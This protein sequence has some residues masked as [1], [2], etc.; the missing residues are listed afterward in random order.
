MPA[1]VVVRDVEVAGGWGLGGAV[2]VG[3]AGCVGDTESRTIMAATV[4]TAINEI[5]AATPPGVT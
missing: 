5:T 4:A 2:E 1:A 3:A